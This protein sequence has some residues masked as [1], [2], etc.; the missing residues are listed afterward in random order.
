MDGDIGGQT[1]RV[2][3]RDA[4]GPVHERL[5]RAKP[6]AA[7]ARGD[8]T[9]GD[10]ARLLGKLGAYYF[11][12]SAH[13]PLDPRRL[14][15]LSNDLEALGAPPPGRPSLAG[16]RSE[17]A[18]LGWRYV[19]DGSIFGGR[20]IHRQLDY[21][22]GAVECGRRFFRGPAGAAAEWQRLCA[23]LEQAGSAQGARDEM[24]AGARD[25]F[26]AFEALIEEDTPANA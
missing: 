24:I 15:L 11:A 19:V 3:L 4:T 25:A 2:A 16:P 7:L 26:A 20:V 5:H 1:V 6:F 12:A 14:A 9:L 13:V 17:P 10:Y 18:R 8:L 23:Q 22:F 21:L